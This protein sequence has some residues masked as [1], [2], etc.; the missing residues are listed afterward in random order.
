MCWP[1]DDIFEVFS[2]TSEGIRHTLA[3]A[4]W[5]TSFRDLI[6]Y[7]LLGALNDNNV[8][9]LLHLY[10]L[11]LKGYA[12]EILD[13]GD[14]TPLAKKDPHGIMALWLMGGPFPICPFFGKFFDDL[15]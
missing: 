11:L 4:P 3:D 13:H 7:Q 10:N 12:V 6:L 1:Q 9:V 5:S 2:I 15:H 14:F 8:P